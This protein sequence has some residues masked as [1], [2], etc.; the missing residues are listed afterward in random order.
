MIKN[1]INKNTLVLYL[2]ALEDGIITKDQFHIL[3]DLPSVYFGKELITYMAGNNKEKD[4]IFN[5]IIKM[6]QNGECFHINTI[7]YILLNDDTFSK[8]SE[9][10][11]AL[12]F[13]DKSINQIFLLTKV[14]ADDKFWNDKEILSI[15]E[16]ISDY[17]LMEQLII[18]AKDDYFFDKKNRELFKRIARISNVIGMKVF[19]EVIK[20]EIVRNDEEISNHLLKILNN[21]ELAEKLHD[22]LFS[23]SLKKIVINNK[24]NNIRGILLNI[25]GNVKDND[26]DLFKIKYLTM[27]IN[28]RNKEKFNQIFDVI[29]SCTNFLEVRSAV[30]LLSYNYILEKPNIFNKIMSISDIELRFKL[31]LLAEHEE[32]MSDISFVEELS[33][34]KNSNDIFDK[35]RKRAMK[36]NPKKFEQIIFSGENNYLP[37]SLIN[38]I[39]K[40]K[41][42]Q[43]IEGLLR[44]K[45][46]LYSKDNEFK[47]LDSNNRSKI[48]VI[49][50]VKTIFNQFKNEFRRIM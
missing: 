44:I 16:S 43:S 8:N 2:N 50:K 48:T 41:N 38:Y 23:E 30:Q 45:K 15:I 40:N 14:Y 4:K 49:T 10:L 29:F 25:T 1:N 35:I 47:K 20:L 13:N 32:I 11:N 22:S 39:D 24:Y 31:I 7:L 5:I 34:L 12:F 46:F 3:V 36:I 17:Q 9:K 27:I 33:L 42:T 28:E 19:S 6:A 26:L 37:K 21:Q 18:I